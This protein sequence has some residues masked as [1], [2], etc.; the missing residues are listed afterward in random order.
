MERSSPRQLTFSDN[1]HY[2][3]FIRPVL[4][5]WALPHLAGPTVAG[6]SGMFR[7][8]S[9]RHRISKFFSQTGKWLTKCSLTFPSE[10]LG[11][12]GIAPDASGAEG[13]KPSARRWWAFVSEELVMVAFPP[14]SS[15]FW[16]QR[17]Q[18]GE[19]SQAV[20]IER[21]C[22]VRSSLQMWAHSVIL[23]SEK[24]AFA[25]SFNGFQQQRWLCHYLL[26]A[27]SAFHINKFWTSWGN[28][29]QPLAVKAKESPEFP[30]SYVWA[31]DRIPK[32]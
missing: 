16:Q 20:T 4:K 27:R 13:G 3:E 32:S 19:H 2:W 1:S 8:I 10:R 22:S 15:Y 28:S 26:F 30:V 29:F 25:C 24:S 21:K 9:P 6:L 11:F 7:G 31:K 23:T 5:A 18:W 12:S 14:E 17:L